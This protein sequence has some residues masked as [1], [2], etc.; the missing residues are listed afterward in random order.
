M[1]RKKVQFEAGDVFGIP[2]PD[3]TFGV[4]QVAL[5][6]RYE[7]ACALFGVRGTS[8]ADLAA[9]AADLARPLTILTLTDEELETGEWP[10]VAHRPADYSAFRIPTDG[11][12]TSH[13]ATAGCG[14]LA[15]CHGLEPWDGM[16][17]PRYY[18]KLLIPGVPIPPTVRY[19]RDFAGDAHAAV[20]VPHPPPV[21]EGPAQI[22]IQIVYPGSGLPSTDL[23][24]RRQE[25]ERRLEAAGA[26]EIEGAESG[27]GVMEIFLRTDEV[28][29]A[30]PLVEK[31]AAELGFADDLLIETAPVEDEDD[32][33]E[34]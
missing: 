4:G 9:R 1:S 19:K 25:L 21:T 12:G 32:N 14:F 33:D 23:L 11:A 18:E 28:R 24:R 20:A 16:F 6:T 10:I 13:T 31:A 15:A 17:D 5:C 26:G 8:L 34:P 7:T 22:T 30:V 2:L 27:S 29:R 3:G